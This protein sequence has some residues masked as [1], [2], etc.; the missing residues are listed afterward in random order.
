[1]IN[2][3]SVEDLNRVIKNN[4]H[5]IPEV[6]A[7]VGIP[8]SGMLPATLLALY[9][10]KP[11][12]MADQLFTGGQVWDLT[13]RFKISVSA[14][15]DKPLLVIDDSCDSGNAMALVKD[16][17]N[18]F[19]KNGKFLYSAVYVTEKGK[20]HVDFYFEQVEQ[21]RVF[22][23]NILDHNILTK[24]CVDLDGVLCR[25]PTDEENDDGERYR[26]FLRDAEV[27]FVPHYEINSI[28]SCRLEKYRPETEIWLKRHGIKYKN[29]FLLNVPDAKTRQ[30]LGAY[31]Q[32]KADIYKALDTQLFIESDPLQA[33]VINNLSK[34]PV[35]CLSDNIFYKERK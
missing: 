17:I 30:L 6:C 34:K 19:I 9:L 26:A 1:M 2:Y 5:T 23:W 21:P 35:Y 3:R 8:R 27:K 28:V 29:L 33:S 13:N 14:T 16:R 18:T 15:K 24:A 22:E 11:V 25:D 20:N 4:L 12:I 10:G 7:I 32:Y 31:S